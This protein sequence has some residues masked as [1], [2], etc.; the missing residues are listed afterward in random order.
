MSP[1]TTRPTTRSSAW[2]CCAPAASSAAAARPWSSCATSSVAPRRAESALQG[3]LDGRAQLR[4]LRRHLAVEEGDDLAV[5]ADEVLAEVPAR[6]LVGGGLQ[7]G[8]DGALL[9]A[10]L[11]L[12]LGEEREGH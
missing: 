2:K 6:Q 3:L 8:V 10:L 4:I 5:L 7:P 9:R 12:H 1:W 11:G